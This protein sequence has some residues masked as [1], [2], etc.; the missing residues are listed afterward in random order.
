MSEKKHLSKIVETI[1]DAQTILLATHIFPDGDALGSLIGL[2][3]IL[4]SMGKKVVYYAEEEVTYLYDFLPSCEKITTRLPDLDGLDCA[5]ALDCGDRLRL[6]AA[7]DDLL[8]IHP[9]MVLDHHAGHQEFGDLR[10]VAPQMPSTGS[11]VYELAGLLGVDISYQAAY[12]LYTAIVSDTGSFKYASTTAGTFRVAG[13]LVA[14]GVKPEEIAGK[15]FDNFTENRLHL[16][17]LV[18]ASL[19]L[20]S[21]GTIAVITASEEMFKKS[22]A[23]PC[24][25]ETFINYPRSLAKVK[26]AVFFKENKDVV[27]VSLRSK[28]ST[29]DMA[30]VAKQFGG[31]GHRNA[32]GFKIKGNP[33]IEE[34][35]TNLFA[36]LQPLVGS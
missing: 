11:M 15:L 25:T 8:N 13:E 36:V 30:Q 16:L 14:K 23:D 17:Q 22:G 28:G 9:F 18:L 3:D 1:K 35:R 19:E 20:F 34:V 10:W 29:Y 6:G 21:D 24:D 12:C 33:D 32:A 26:I 5:I 27:G 7:M 2:G 4:E 31:G